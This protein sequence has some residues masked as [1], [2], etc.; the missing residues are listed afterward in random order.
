MIYSKGNLFYFEFCI[1]RFSLLE[2]FHFKM[3][4]KNFSISILYLKHYFNQRK[5]M[6]RYYSTI[7]FKKMCIKFSDKLHNFYMFVICFF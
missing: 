4:V 2:V 6:S 1:R 3:N 5:F 7:C